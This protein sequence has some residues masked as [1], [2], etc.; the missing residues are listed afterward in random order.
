[1]F[2]SK[3]EFIDHLLKEYNRLYVV[4][5]HTDGFLILSEGGI[6]MTEEMPVINMTATGI[7]IKA[8]I[9][10]KGLRTFWV[11]TLLSP[12]SNGCEGSPYPLSTIW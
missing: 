5:T 12:F 9:K 4:Q 10:A 8:L 3:I 7:N 11:S 1:M 6:I 2:S